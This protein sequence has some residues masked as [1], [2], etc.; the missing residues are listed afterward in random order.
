M[1]Q[2]NKYKSIFDGMTDEE[3]EVILEESGFKYKKVEPGKGSIKILQ[4]E[5]N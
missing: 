2:D 3:F 5:D 4:Q 1:E